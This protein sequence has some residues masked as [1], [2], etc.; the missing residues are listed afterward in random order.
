M[1]D[2]LPIITIFRH[3]VLNYIKPTIPYLSQTNFSGLF[4]RNSI[5]Y[6]LCLK[7]DFAILKVRTALKRSNSVRYYA[8]RNKIY[9]FPRKI[10]NNIRKWK[11]S[12]WSCRICKN[13]IPMLVSRSIFKYKIIFSALFICTH[14]IV[15]DLV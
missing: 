6:N 8:W 3:Y 7:S 5:S 2:S 9:R 10:W 1:Y 15:L 14:L 4:T 13:Y 11:P 12:G